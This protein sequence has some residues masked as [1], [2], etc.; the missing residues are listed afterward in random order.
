[1]QSWADYLGRLKAQAMGIRL[2]S[3]DY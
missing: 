2:I 3:N 1:M